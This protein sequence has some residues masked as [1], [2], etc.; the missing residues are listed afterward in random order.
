MKDKVTEIGGNHVQYGPDSQ[1]IYLMG[2]IRGD[3]ENMADQL[4]KL[5]ADDRK[6]I[7]KIFARVPKTAEEEFTAEDGWQVGATV[8]GMYNG[9]VDGLFLEK[10]LDPERAVVAET[11]RKEIEKVIEQAETK[12]DQYKSKP[13]PDRFEMRMVEEADAEQV[14]ELYGQAFGKYPFPIDNPEYIRETLRKNILYAGVWDRKSGDLVTAA[15]CELD[16]EAENG[17]L[18]DAAASPRYRRFGFGITLNA[19]L[20]TIMRNMGIKTS[21][22]ITRATELPINAIAT[23]LSYKFAGILTNNTGISSEGNDDPD[24]FESMNVVYKDLTSETPNE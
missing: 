9:E 7:S 11:T 6:V 10:F 24:Y 20:E 19:Y 1:R 3:Y 13:M 4:Q 8:P 15:S 14:A 17:E 18:S 23:R 21:Y 5:A 2:S 22:G 16:R 12:R